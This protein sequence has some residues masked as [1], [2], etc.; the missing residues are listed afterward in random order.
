MGLLLAERQREGRKSWPRQAGRQATASP[1]SLSGVSKQALHKEKRACYFGTTSW[2]CLSVYF[3]VLPPT[4]IMLSCSWCCCGT[5]GRG[6]RQ[7]KKN[8]LSIVFSFPSPGS[9]SPPLHLEWAAC[10]F[11]VTKTNLHAHTWG[12]F[13]SY[14]YMRGTVQNCICLNTCHPITFMHKHSLCFLSACEN[15]DV[16]WETEHTGGDSSTLCLP[17]GLTPPLP[18]CFSLSSLCLQKPTHACLSLSLSGDSSWLPA[19]LF[20]PCACC[21][22]LQKNTCLPLVSLTARRGRQAGPLLRQADKRKEGTSCTLEG[23]SS[24]P[25]RETFTTWHRRFACFSARTA[26]APAATRF[27]PS[28]TVEKAPANKPTQTASQWGRPLSPAC[29]RTHPL[30][31]LS[32]LSVSCRSVSL[33]SPKETFWKLSPSPHLLRGGN[34]K[35]KENTAAR[36][37]WKTCLPSSWETCR[38]LSMKLAFVFAHTGFAHTLWHLVR[39]GM[40]HCLEEGTSLTCLSVSLLYLSISIMCVCL[41]PL[42]ST[43]Y[44][45]SV[46]HIIHPSCSFIH[47]SIY[48][49]IFFYV[50]F[51]SFSSPVHSFTHFLSLPFHSEVSEKKRIV[52]F[53]HYFHHVFCCS[54]FLLLQHAFHALFFSFCFASFS[55]VLSPTCSSY[56]PGFKLLPS[57]LSFSFFFLPILLSSFCTPSIK[58]SMCTPVRHSHALFVYKHVWNKNDN[59]LEQT[60][61]AQYSRQNNVLCDKTCDACFNGTTSY[62]LFQWNSCCSNKAFWQNSSML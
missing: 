27:P 20:L 34:G 29:F 59:Q 24:S 6:D 14:L 4:S 32:H 50:Y 62:E 52:R 38:R 60:T 2:N 61:N 36:P 42:F 35:R 10:I 17:S 11:H 28:T 57:S 9:G 45:F 40:F 16:S 33:I 30:K 37:T 55:P 48:V 58:P 56:C 49:F 26:A 47:F 31:S 44:F 5:F 51:L 12:S 43:S 7:N 15:L 19:W 18:H 41:H 39:L 23:G 13:S 1:L 8:S 46:L 22:L 21:M 3:G 53:L 25:S 54:F